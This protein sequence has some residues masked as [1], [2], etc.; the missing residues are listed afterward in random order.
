MAKGRKPAGR[1]EGGQARTSGASEKR[2]KDTLIHIKS[3][4][5]RAKPAKCRGAKESNDKRATK[6]S[7]LCTWMPHGRREVAKWHRLNNGR[8]SDCFPISASGLVRCLGKGLP[9]IC[10]KGIAHTR[11]ITGRPFPSIAGADS[12]DFGKRFDTLPL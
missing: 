3:R 4:D 9:I 12:A 8:A 7:A 6:A 11:H 1:G 5:C 10:R 2:P